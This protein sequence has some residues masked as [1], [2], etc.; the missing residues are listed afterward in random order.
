MSD[1]SNISLNEIENTIM[2]VLVGN[3]GIVFTQYQLFDKVIDKLEIKINCIH[4]R[5]E[6]DAVKHWSNENKMEPMHF[7]SIVEEKYIDEIKKNIDKNDIT[8]VLSYNYD[9]KVIKF[10]RDNFYNYIL[11]PKMDA[12]RD[13][14]AI[15]DL[16]IGQYCNNV[17]IFVYESSFSYTLL[18]R[19]YER[20]KVKPIQLELVFQQSLIT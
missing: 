20:N 7:K 1:L 9:N 15:N 6:D 5:L 2:L 16:L 11:T 13:I 10:L 18:C 17:Y 4:L 12:N 14:A 19:I 3:D 8:I